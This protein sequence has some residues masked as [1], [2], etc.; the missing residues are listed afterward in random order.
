MGPYA[1]F[2]Y[3]LTLCH[4]QSRL[5]HFSHGQPYSRV[6]LNPMSESTSSPSQ[7]FWIWPLVIGVCKI[8]QSWG[9]V[10]MTAGQDEPWI[11]SLNILFRWCLHEIS[12]YTQ[13][14]ANLYTASKRLLFISVF[15]N[16][17]LYTVTHNFIHIN[18]NIYIFEFLK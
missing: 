16:D 14:H 7:R 13:K 3:Y 5:Q 2:D 1:G 15:I 8:H 10:W 4:L 9:E 11:S 18:T 17:Y 6:D 12:Q